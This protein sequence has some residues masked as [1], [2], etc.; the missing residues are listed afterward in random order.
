MIKVVVFDL[1]DTLIEESKFTLSGL[2]YNAKFL[3]KHLN[4]ELELVHDLLLKSYKANK[5]K[6][7]NHFFDIQGINYSDSL[8]DYLI[9]SHRNHLPNI[10]LDD[11]TIKILEDLSNDFNL[12]LITDGFKESQHNKIRVLNLNQWFKKIIVTDDLG[13]E[14]WKPHPLSFISI[15]EHFNCEYSEM[16]YVGDNVK[17]DFI[18]PNSLGMESILVKSKSRFKTLDI[19]QLNKFEKPSIIMKDLFELSIYLRNIKQ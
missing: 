18:A 11:Q 16:V 1:D 6:T 9:K 13:R 7:Y 19:N 3:S 12:A 10:A 4:L 14:Y 17:K 2:S 8:I 5:V 15:K